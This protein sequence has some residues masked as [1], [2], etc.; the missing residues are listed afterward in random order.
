M[1][2]KICRFIRS[3]VLHIVRGSPKSSL[4]LIQKR[5]SICKLCEY[6]SSE[7]NQCLQC[8]CNIG[9]EPIFMNKLAWLDQKCPIDKW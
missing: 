8:G 6:I 1:M 9:E 4:S 7:K 3:F 5:Y 2:K